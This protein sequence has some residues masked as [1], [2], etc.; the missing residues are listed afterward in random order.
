M[1]GIWASSLTL[2]SPGSS[3]RLKFESEAGTP[4]EAPGNFQ[5][6]AGSLFQADKKGLNS[7][8]PPC[9]RVTVVSPG[10]EE[11]RA[12]GGYR[13]PARGDWEPLRHRRVSF[14]QGLFVSPGAPGTLCQG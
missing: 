2:V 14:Q 7:K 5:P 13:P 1:T 6:G 11:E 8:Q 4:D 10:Q 9:P 3:S 12:W